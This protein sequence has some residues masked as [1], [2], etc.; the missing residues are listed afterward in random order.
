MICISVILAAAQPTTVAP[1]EPA[2]APAVASGAVSYP[3]AFFADR[4]ANTALEMVVAIPG[5]GFNPGGSSLRGYSGSAGNVLIDGARPT[6]KTDTV[7]EVLRRIPAS[8]VE[9]IEVIRGGAPGIDMQGQAVVANVI[10]RPGARTSFTTIVGGQHSGGRLSPSA[11]VES[12]RQT[13]GRSF[14]GSFGLNRDSRGDDGARRTT[15]TPEGAPLLLRRSRYENLSNRI[16]GAVRGE[17]KLSEASTARAN[18]TFQASDGEAEGDGEVRAPGSA[19]ANADRFV[20]AFRRAELE[21]GGELNRK[22]GPRADLKLIAS[23]QLE[24]SESASTFA[25]AAR[26]SG[27]TQE[28]LKGES[29]VRGTLA[30][31]RSPTLSFETG[32]EAAYNFLDQSFR[33]SVAGKAVDLP[34]QSVLVTE[35]RAEA[36]VQASWKPRPRW[37]LDGAVR[38]EASELEQSG[39]V[40]ARSRFFFPKPRLLVSWA[41]DAQ[42]QWRLRLERTVG[43]LDFSDFVSSASL[44]TLRVEAGNPDLEPE[45]ASTAG[46]NYERRFWSKGAANLSF[47]HSEIEQAIDRVPIV[48]A[49]FVFDAPGNIGR[50]RTSTVSG[51]LTLPTDKLRV[52]GGTLR[53]GANR[54]WSEVTDP[55][56]GEARAIS[57]RSPYFLNAG[58]SQD[59]ARWRTTWSVNGFYS[60]GQI[61]YAIDEI[62]EFEIGPSISASVEYKPTDKW[63]IS[64]NATPPL[65]DFVFRRTLYS[66]PRD[67]GVIAS[68]EESRNPRRGSISLRLRRTR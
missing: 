58:F 20:S 38:F 31:R 52:P 41:P 7:D 54:T 3:A 29:I 27:S 32:A 14:D 13:P 48:G 37:T 63:A 23:Q 24:P 15:F 45:R 61:S 18:L 12:A 68:I 28:A 59:L 19:E 66:A 22:L 50:G 39:D 42:T 55:V 34:S 46:L 33:L 25:T 30:A 17:A 9:R 4:R 2:P 47:S 43:Q 56:T 35:R 5:F 6:S 62:D 8:A 64:L 10:R 44:E 57:D 1:P 60:P 51:S 21:F 49:G 36:F 16:E 40:G 67:R 65:G 53:L 26:E 11:R